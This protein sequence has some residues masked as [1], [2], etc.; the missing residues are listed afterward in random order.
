MLT[1]IPQNSIIL[2]TGDDL[3]FPSL[4]WQYFKGYRRDVTIINFT[5]SANWY[6]EN[7]HLQHPG[8]KYLSNPQEF[9]HYLCSDIAAQGKL[10]VFPWDPGFETLFGGKCIIIPFGLLG[11]V[12]PKK[13]VPN[14]EQ[15][16]SVT[17]AEW[18]SYLQQNSVEK[19]RTT[20]SRTREFLLSLADQLTSTGFYYQEVGE[21]NWAFNEFIQANA[22]SPDEV[23]ALISESTMYYK[24]NDVGTAMSLLEEGIQRNPAVAVL[25]KNLGVY[26]LR[27]N[28]K[29]MAYQNFKQYLN[30]SPE[31]K[32]APAIENYV[33]SYQLTGQ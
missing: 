26:Y 22:F 32:D 24:R 18:K 20:S 17:D 29:A 27:V 4:Y 23:S 28:N 7:L 1:E 3:Y 30:F 9:Y 16:K 11:K 25:Y 21:S 5:L 19:Y 2:T 10:Y 15:I 6:L 13:M 8:L 31:D 12:T 14:P 33:D